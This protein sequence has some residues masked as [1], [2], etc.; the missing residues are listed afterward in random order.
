[1]VLLTICKFALK[2]YAVS[3]AWQSYKWRNAVVLPSTNKYT[4]GPK[5]RNREQCT[6]Q[7]ACSLGAMEA[8]YLFP[9]AIIYVPVELTTHVV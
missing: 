7:T 5:M 4:G 8:C 6:W 1:M 9:F 3:F 2:S